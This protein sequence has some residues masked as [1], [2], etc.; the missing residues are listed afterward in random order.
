MHT[1]KYGWRHPTASAYGTLDIYFNFSSE[2]RYNYE[3]NLK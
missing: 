3:D 2:L 1:K